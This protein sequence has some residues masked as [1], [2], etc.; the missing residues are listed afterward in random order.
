MSDRKRIEYCRKCIASKKQRKQPTPCGTCDYGRPGEAL[1]AENEEALELWEAVATQW[2]AGGMG[3]VGLDYAEVR[4]WAS[5]LAIDLSPCLWS[6]IRALERHELE[7][8]Y[9]DRG[10]AGIEKPAAEPFGGKHAPEKGARN[11]G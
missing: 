9:A 6:K 11:R 3:V 8:A 10:S 5:D 1:R 4:A 2:R 7:R